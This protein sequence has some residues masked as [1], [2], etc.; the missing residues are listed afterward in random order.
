[1]AFYYYETARKIV[2]MHNMNEWRKFEIDKNTDEIPQDDLHSISNLACYSFAMAA[3][4]LAITA[5][6]LNAATG[7]RRGSDDGGD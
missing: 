3:F 1:M 7:G 6:G 2:K 4:K 5:D